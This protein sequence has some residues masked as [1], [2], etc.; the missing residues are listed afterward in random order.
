MK[1]SNNQHRSSS[2]LLVSAKFDHSW[3]LADLVEELA[4]EKKI[5]VSQPEAVTDGWNTMHT[6]SIEAGVSGNLIFSDQD[7]HMPFTTGFMFI[8]TRSA[9]SGSKLTWSNSLS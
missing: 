8:C 6:S 2:Q 3:F 7:I 5:T 1:K 9:N 4:N